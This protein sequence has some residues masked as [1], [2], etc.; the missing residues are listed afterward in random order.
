MRKRGLRP[1]FVWEAMKR[2]GFTL[3][4]TLIAIVVLCMILFIALP[5]YGVR[6]KKSEL[7]DAKA[8]L[9]TIKES[10]DRYKMENGVYTTDT[11]KLV[12]WK[13]GTKKYRFQVEYA[14]TSR[15]TAQANGDMDN[16][17]VYDDDIWAINQ[18][19]TLT[20]IK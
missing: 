7:V 13:T 18:S 4:E 2:N 11:T 12:N 19:G 20:K 15:F 16:D 8:Q 17:K 6:A 9:M 10:Q 14:D 5:M 3:V 1:P